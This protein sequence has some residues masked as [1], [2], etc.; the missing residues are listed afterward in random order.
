MDA[1]KKPNVIV[2]FGNDFAGPGMGTI[3]LHDAVGLHRRNM[4]SSV[5]CGSYRPSAVPAHMIRS[6]GLAD[7]GFRKLASLDTSN[8]L[9]Y[10]QAMWF[11]LWAS[12]HLD[13]A[14]VL[15]VW[16]GYG[17]RSLTKAKQRGMLTVSVLV[18]THPHY[19]HRLL[20]AEYARWGQTWKALP[21]G[22]RRSA[23]E[24][25]RADYVLVPSDIVR[26]SC[27]EEGIEESKLLV[28]PFGVDVE[29]F[30][31]VEQHVDRPFRVIFVGRIG[32][33]KGIP[34]LLEAWKQ[35]GWRD[36]ELW[37]VGRVLPEARAILAEHTGLPGV[38]QL[39]FMRHPAETYRQC[40]LFVFPTIEEGSALVIY[41]A[42]ACGLPIVTAPNAGAVA[43]DGVEGFIV[44][45]RDV[46]ALATRMEQ[47]RADELL[48]REMGRAA[49][50]RAR[51][52]TWEQH[53]D[54]LSA[55][56]TG[57]RNRRPSH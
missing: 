30:A 8:W 31:P 52:F 29:R 26:R 21:A 24:L 54:Q 11:D 10:F 28:L 36:A 25:E 17:S 53:G 44:P 2:S 48:R 19:Q 40:D 57:L 20:S 39:G 49:R 27:L 42:M 38:R 4:L 50:E 37:L 35:L 13:K 14:D 15:H 5:L 55:M 45:I 6:I 12:R 47:L 51:Q 22:L 46:D 33:R 7:R 41:E 43:R 9:W 1:P 56:Y 32:I 18:S 16:C 34:Y 3:A 23:S